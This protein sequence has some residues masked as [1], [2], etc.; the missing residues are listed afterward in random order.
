[1]RAL[2][3]DGHHRLATFPQP[4]AQHWMRQ[5]RARFLQGLDGVKLAAIAAA[6]ARDLREDE[7]HPVAL[8]P[9]GSQFRQDAR[10][11]LCLRGDKA[12]Q[13]HTPAFF[14]GTS[15]IAAQSLSCQPQATASS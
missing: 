9:A 2:V 13:A 15:P 3:F 10:I 12:L 4:R 14:A 1:M 8:L 7:P 6:Q 11:D 5:I